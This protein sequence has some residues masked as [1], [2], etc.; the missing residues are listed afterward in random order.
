MS[1]WKSGLTWGMERRRIESKFPRK[2]KVPTTANR[3]PSTILKQ[4]GI[5]T[6]YL[7]IQKERGG[8]QEMAPIREPTGFL[9]KSVG[10]L[11]QRG[12]S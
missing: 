12:D 6:K 2:P 7:G 3:T 5:L 4:M 8:Y 9:R 10:I 11:K 1:F